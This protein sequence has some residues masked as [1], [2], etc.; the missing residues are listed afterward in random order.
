MFISVGGEIRIERFDTCVE[1]GSVGDW[2]G[3]SSYREW[4]GDAQLSLQC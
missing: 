2:A 1:I 4:R 3:V